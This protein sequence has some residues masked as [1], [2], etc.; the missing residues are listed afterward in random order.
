MTDKFT[1]EQIE[2]YKKTFSLFDK[3]GDGIIPIKDLDIIFRSLQPTSSEAEIQDYMKKID[4]Y[5]NG[6]LDFPEFLSIIARR[7][8]DIDMEKK[9]IETK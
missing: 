2:E 3:E 9:L 4:D 5:P 7:I 6:N 1:E 8:I